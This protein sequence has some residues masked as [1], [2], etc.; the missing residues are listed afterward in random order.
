GGRLVLFMIHPAFRAPRGSGW[1]YDERRKLVYRRV[2]RYLSSAAVPMKSYAEAGAGSRG[3]TIS[4]H[5][6]L[7][8]Y[9]AALA[10]NGFVIDALLEL[11]DPVKGHD[12]RTDSPEI[13]LFLALRARRV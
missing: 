9:V 3:A 5:R 4:F 8:D 6:P 10:A 1:G 2:E 11:A 7:Q 12:E 13:P